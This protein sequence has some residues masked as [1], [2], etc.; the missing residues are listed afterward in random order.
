[1]NHFLPNLPISA[2]AIIRNGE[3]PYK[4]GRICHA[5]PLISLSFAPSDPYHHRTHL[6]LQ[7]KR[8]IKKPQRRGQLH[9]IMEEMRLYCRVIAHIEL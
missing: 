7:S 3:I 1:M 8:E 4:T 5:K 6:A 9:G 2:I